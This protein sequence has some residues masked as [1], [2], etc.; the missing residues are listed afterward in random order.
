MII[1]SSCLSSATT[2]GVL[3]DTGVRQFT[4]CSDGIAALAGV[5]GIDA[6]ELPPDL[7]GAVPSRQWQFRAGRLCAQHA[8]VALGYPRP[9]V[10]IP[11]TANGAPGWPHGVT[12]SITH[13]EGYVSA[14]VARSDVI[15]ALGI[16]SERIVT[17]D[18]L[19]SIVGTIAWA[20]ELAAARDAGY[21]R[22]V[23][24]TLV[25]SAK[26]TIFKCLSGHV[27]R[28]FDFRDVRVV[29]INATRH[30]FTARLVTTL[31]P[32]W[33]AGVML[34]GGFAVET[35]FVHTGMT[36]SAVPIG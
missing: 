6:V 5:P 23:S 12:G 30:Q 4:I 28:V 36:L 35:P 32:A 21:D 20:S 27:G 19:R 34:T 8:L 24:A 17:E 3:P 11:R 31:S 2:T 16:D 15:S 29:G 25:F 18:R 26:E 1:D 7:V 22:L 10:R 9:D 13:T 33:R 14:A